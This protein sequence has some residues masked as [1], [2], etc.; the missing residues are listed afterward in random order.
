MQ[1]IVFL[2]LDDTILQTRPKCPPDEPIE[3]AAHGRDGQPLSFITDRQRALL[4]LFGAATVIPTTARNRDAFRRVR[5]P[6]SG[7]A[8]LDFGGVILRP[9]GTPDPGWDAIVRPQACH[10]GPELLAVLKDVQAFIAARGLGVNARLIADFD[11][12]LYLVLKH[13]AGDCAAL[14]TVRREHWG[15]IETDRFFVHL[16]GNN[17]SLV[18]R[19]LGK[20]RAVRHV[21]DQLIPAGPRLVLGAGD[22]FTDAPFLGLCDFALLPR[23]SQLMTSLLEGGWR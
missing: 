3:P 12:P 15:G 9:D 23:Q 4:A 10:V 7:H 11:M 2:D 5:L 6:F 22:S 21:L 20:E 18:P 8:I 1:T 16:T 19:F 14:Q 13:P 17:L